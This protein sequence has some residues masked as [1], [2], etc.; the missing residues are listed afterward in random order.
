MQR[1]GPIKTFLRVGYL[2]LGGWLVVFGAANYLD[3]HHPIIVWALH[4]TVMIVGIIF[5]FSLFTM[6]KNELPGMVILS[7]FLLAMGVIPFESS[8]HFHSD[9]LV[10]AI[11]WGVSLLA[12]C[13][14]PVGL[15]E[16]RWGDRLSLAFLSVWLI[17]WPIPAFADERK[18]VLLFEALLPV[19]VGL[20]ILTNSLIV[21]LRPKT[22]PA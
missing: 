11:L 1:D 8:F 3:G 10:G 7:I 21:F 18:I 2:L 20:I 4:L 22:T 6:S 15:A 12:G 19:V 16:K 9:N 5:L 17:I 13:L 14:I